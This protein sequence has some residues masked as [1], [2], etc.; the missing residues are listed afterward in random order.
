MILVQKSSEVK[1]MS[2]PMSLVQFLEKNN[3][4]VT[5][6]EAN[7]CGV[8]NE[9][10]CLLTKEEELIRVGFGIYSLP[11]EFIDR[12]YITQ[13]QKNK[14]IYSHETALYLHDLTD[15][16][17]IKYAVT[18][19]TGYSSQKLKQENFMVFSVKAE[20]HELGITQKETIFGN[21]VNVYN[22][23]RTICD[24]IRSRQK[25]D[26][27]IVTDALKVYSKRKDKNLNSLMELAEKF[28]ISKLLRNYM[29]V[30]L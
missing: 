14:I 13:K 9:R 6:Y 25:M 22:M 17:P 2:I 20:L 28:H 10:L 19:P 11:D 18:V 30:L 1:V 8:S 23:E 27:S 24:C 21:L 4:L 12:M 7:K 29:E 26:A 3:G 5:T 15:R 16:D